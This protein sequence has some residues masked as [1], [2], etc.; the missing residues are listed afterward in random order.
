MDLK[1]AELKNIS[2]SD[3]TELIAR[4]SAIGDKIF[5]GSDK[6]GNWELYSYD[7]LTKETIRLTNNEAF[8]GDP[9]IFRGQKTK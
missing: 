6:D 4:W 8:D 5:Y 2:N 3:G 7:L 1:S 9:R